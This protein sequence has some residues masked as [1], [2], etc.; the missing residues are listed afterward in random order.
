MAWS[1]SPLRMLR[2]AVCS[3]TNDD[4]HNVSIVML[5]PDRSRK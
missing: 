2:T 3:A 5:G 1:H 4:E